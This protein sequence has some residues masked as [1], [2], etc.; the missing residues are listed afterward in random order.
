MMKK[1]PLDQII[2]MK[3]LLKYVFRI[4]LLFAGVMMILLP[5]NGCVRYLIKAGYG[6]MKI[7]SARQP[8]SEV[9]QSP[10]TDE[11]TRKKLRH[12]LKIQKYAEDSMG[13]DIS[14]SYKK[15]ARIDRDAAAYNVTASE[16]LAF[17]PKTWYFPI[18]GR[19]PYLGFFSREEAENFKKE[20]EKEGWDANVSEVSAYSTLGWFEDPLL[21]SQLS[22]PDWYLTRLIL[23]EA[24]HSTVWFQDDVNFNESLATFVEIEGALQYY[25]ATEG[26]QSMLRKKKFIEENQALVAIIN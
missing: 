2:L 23:H 13:L 7:L 25:S 14:N 5:L 1:M 15:Y 19:V 12:V 21:S 11:A 4:F 6:Q 20:L 17:I 9:I 24:T 3:L 8:I 18:V 10:D 22:Y 16:E 26:R